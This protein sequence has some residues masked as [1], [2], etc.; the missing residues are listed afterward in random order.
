MTKT[1]HPMQQS[2]G[3]PGGPLSWRSE[4][5]LVLIALV[6]PTVMT[7]LYFVQFAGQSGWMI[8]LY[9]V[10][11][12]T[13]VGIALLPLVMVRRETG[14]WPHFPLRSCRGM[15]WG[16]FFGAITV[17][18][19]IW[20]Y[21]TQL[22]GSPALERA[23]AAVGQKLR[24]IGI[25]TAWHFLGMAVFLSVL[26]AAFEEYYWRWFVFGQLR[27]GLPWGAALVVAS[28]GFTLHHVIVIYIYVPSWPWT[29]LFSLGVGIGGGVWAWIYQK[30]GSLAG[31]WVSHMLI[32]FGL[33]W[34]GYDLCQGMWT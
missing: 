31:P 29:L 17:G 25:T 9:T 26:H 2:D 22:K 33:M 15:G 14:H 28:V 19:M 20:L 5:V 13:M 23:P 32:D 8:G 12:L 27:R 3:L 18:T 4:G 6:L 7:W 34:I 10:G 21:H 30:S 16:L 24:E 1:L 11:K